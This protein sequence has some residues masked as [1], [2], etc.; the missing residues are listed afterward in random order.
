MRPEEFSVVGGDAPARVLLPGW[1][2]DGRIFGDPPPDAAAVV[3]G[4]L[5]PDGFADR[6]AAFLSGAARGAVTVVGWSLGGFLAADFAR[7]F[8]ERVRRVVLVGVRRR[9]PAAD[10]EAVRASLARDRRGCLSQFYAQCFFPSEMAAYRRFRGALQEE[11][12]CGMDDA[13]LIAGL[14]YLAAATLSAAD[15]PPCPVTIVHGEKDV[16]A[17]AAEA[18]SLAR[19]GRASFHLLPGAPHAAFLSSRFR[20]VAAGG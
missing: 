1:G 12:L 15:L 20:A 16:V 10:L 6:L 14:S 3:A 9:Y 2:T 13:V 8:P 18:R 19:D 11:Y 7:R 17:P 5:R 4:P